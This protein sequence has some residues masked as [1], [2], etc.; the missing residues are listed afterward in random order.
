MGFV[1]TSP[2]T[3]WHACVV[4]I[5]RR[6]GRCLWM[7]CFA[8]MAPPSYGRLASVSAS[9]RSSARS[10]QAPTRNPPAIKAVASSCLLQKVG[11]Y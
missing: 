9:A 3:T 6:K 4:A 2:L 11:G 8:I 10:N 5:S 7:L 1:L